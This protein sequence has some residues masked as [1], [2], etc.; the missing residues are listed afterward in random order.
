MPLLLTKIEGKGNGIKT[1][2]PNMS[3]VSRSLS[4]PPTYPTKF[5]GCELGAQTSF[6]EKADRFIVN[7]AHDA[8]KLRELLDNFIVKFVLCGSCKNPE[9]DLVIKSGDLIRSCKACGERT[10]VD[11]RHKLVTFILKNPPKN[12]KKSKGAPK[13]GATE[14]QGTN[15][16][17]SPKAEA[18]E[19]VGDGAES[20][21]ELAKMKAEAADLDKNATIFR[22]DWSEDTEA[23]KTRM[24]SLG[25]ALGKVKLGD[26]DSGEEGNGDD[27]YSQLGT[28]VTENHNEGPVEVFKK[29]QEMG[30]EKKHRA[31]Q[32]LAQTLFTEDILEEIKLNAPIFSKVCI[33]STEAPIQ[34]SLISDI[35]IDGDV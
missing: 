25:G 17:N 30:L 11:M 8:T 12:P 18:E 22:E 5:F 6:D 35:I 19:P 14:T 27:P 9:T 31:I 16:Q 29:V 20:D 15:E 2:L 4:R 7:G 21:V 10:S 33:H 34:S 1:V 32:V 13:Q 23:V 26:D 28:W 24:E 3:D